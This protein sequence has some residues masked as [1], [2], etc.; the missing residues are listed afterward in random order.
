MSSFVLAGRSYRHSRTLSAA[1]IDPRRADVHDRAE[2]RVNAKCRLAPIEPQSEA[3]QGP[4]E[5]VDGYW[6]IDKETLKVRDF[7]CHYHQTFPSA[8][9]IFALACSA[10]D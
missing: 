9:A 6:G 1:S 2:R 8:L 5:K 3:D 10:A 7:L 4:L